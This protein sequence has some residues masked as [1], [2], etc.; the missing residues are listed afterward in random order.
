MGTELAFY[1][2][3]ILS[4]ASFSGR[5]ITSITAD[6][7][8]KEMVSEEAQ[9]KSSTHGQERAVDARTV[10]PHQNVYVYNRS[11]FDRIAHVLKFRVK[12]R[13]HR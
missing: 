8:G 12:A 9:R 3:A 1:L 7:V 5:V 4:G 13:L 6:K 2:T 11:W 10:S